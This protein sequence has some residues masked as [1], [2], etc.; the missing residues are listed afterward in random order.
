M[1]AHVAMWWNALAVLLVAGTLSCDYFSTLVAPQ[2]LSTARVAIAVIDTNGS[3]TRVIAGARVSVAGG[4]ETSDSTGLAL[5]AD[6]ATGVATITVTHPH[7]LTAVDTIDIP[8]DGAEDT[9][10]MQRRSILPQFESIAA[11]PSVT[12]AVDDTVRVEVS[13]MKPVWPVKSVTYVF[14]DG[15]SAVTGSQIFHVYDTAGTYDLTVIIVDENGDTVRDSVE[16]V[17]IPNRRPKI[18]LSVHRQGKFYHDEQDFIDVV[19]H[20][21][22]DNLLYA[23][24]DWDN[25]QLS[26]L[27]YMNAGDSA[28]FYVT[29]ALPDTVDSARFR[30]VVTAIDENGAATRRAA[31]VYVTR[32]EPFVV[33]EDVEFRPPVV[34]G[35]DSVIW[36]GARVYSTH[37][38]VSKLIWLLNGAF[39]TQE[40]YDSTTGLIPMGGRLFEKPIST[41]GLADTNHVTISVVDSKGRLQQPTGTFIIVGN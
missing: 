12:Q 11:N 7:Y 24:V 41:V 31:S 32:A 21:P 19:V 34:T 33:A 25:G 18:E 13:I 10:R 38:Y 29:Y 5:V 1:R 35:S 30:P 3:F 28:R 23:Q 14:G 37:G 9:V 16:V 22:D 20:D 39:V 27:K 15:D 26:H 6:A 4:A 8:L 40:L 17:V 2:E 36:A